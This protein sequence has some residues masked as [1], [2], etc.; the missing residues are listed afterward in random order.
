[1]TAVN[2]ITTG[3]TESPVRRDTRAGVSPTFLFPPKGCAARAYRRRGRQLGTK[4]AIPREEGAQSV[5][6]NNNRIWGPDRSVFS[7]R[8]K[9]FEN[10]AFDGAF[11]L[12]VPFAECFVSIVYHYRTTAVC[13]MPRII[14]F[15]PVVQVHT[16]KRCAHIYILPPWMCTPREFFRE[17]DIDNDR[18]AAKYKAGT[19]VPYPGCKFPPTGYVLRA[20]NE[21]RQRPNTTEN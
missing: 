10:N 7:S 15:H 11:G 4:E 16:V 1:M 18:A 19:T 20:S 9:R 13:C 12:S 2:E 8:I 5:A 14:P 3:S 17:Y 21:T 6:N